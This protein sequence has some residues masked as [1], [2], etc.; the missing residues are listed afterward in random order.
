M[1][2]DV[3]IVKGKWPYKTLDL[4]NQKTVEDLAGFVTVSN[5][6]ECLGGIL[7]SNIEKNLLSTSVSMLAVALWIK[8]VY[9]VENSANRT[10]K[11]HERDY[12]T[13]GCSSTNLV[14]S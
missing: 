2:V 1:L 6:L 4:A 10:L 7:S 14:T 12:K 11:T 9:L 3:M 8:P 5:I 13:Y